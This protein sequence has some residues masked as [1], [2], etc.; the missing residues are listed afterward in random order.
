MTFETALADEPNDTFATATDLGVVSLNLFEDF[1]ISSA[2]DKDYFEFT[3]S[4]TGSLT[5]SALFSH[6]AGDLDI[7]LF[8]LKIGSDIDVH[9]LRSIAESMFNGILQ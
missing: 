6:A 4:E 5:L 1:T 9:R 8:I 3:A 7:Q 2:S